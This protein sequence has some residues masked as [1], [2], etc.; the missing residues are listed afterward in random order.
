MVEIEIEGLDKA[1][2]T[3]IYELA[4]EQDKSVDEVV[5][6]MLREYIDGQENTV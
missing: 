1:T 4:A 6:D 2:I 5:T 3:F